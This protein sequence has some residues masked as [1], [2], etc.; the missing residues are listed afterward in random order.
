MQVNGHDLDA[1][2][3]VQE[4]PSTIQK[5]RDHHHKIAWMVAKGMRTNEIAAEIGY[6][7]SRVSIL[8][9][10]PA[11]KALVEAKRERLE[12]VELEVY[13]DNVKKAYMVEGMSWDE[14]SDM[15]HDKPGEISLEQHLQVI[16][17]AREAQFG[18]VSRSFSVNANLELSLAEQC[19][20]RMQRAN[21][22]EAQ[23]LK[24]LPPRDGPEHVTGPGSQLSPPTPPAAVPAPTDSDG[25][26]E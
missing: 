8:K 18:K 23:A 22:L 17:V 24:S 2:D 16:Q 12:Q 4:R 26:T 7:V 14:L 9:G 6:T 5:I 1:L 19:E 15:Y 11:F 10:D 13:A 3:R 20:A 21:Q 25:R